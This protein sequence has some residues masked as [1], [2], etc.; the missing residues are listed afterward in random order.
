MVFF[1]VVFSTQVFDISDSMYVRLAAGLARGMD[2]R[3]SGNS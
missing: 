1:S 3:K 2:L